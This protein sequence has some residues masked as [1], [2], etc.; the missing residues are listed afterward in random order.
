VT[1][2]IHQRRDLAANQLETAVG[3]FI[4][5][6]DRFSVITLAGAADAILSQLV[7][8]K[9]ERTFIEGLIEGAENEK[10]ACSDMGKH[11]ND[12]LFINALK[13]M[14]KDDDGSVV[15]DVEECAL[16][17]MLVAMA[18]FVTLNGRGTDFVEAFFAWVKLNLDPAIYNI[19]CDPDWKP[20]ATD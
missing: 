8:N 17:S 3:L 16:A 20:P 4:S 5:G 7:K 6:H 12:V 13:H 9:G 14:D 2:Q 10:L 15:M 18:N 11:V 1:T 19:D